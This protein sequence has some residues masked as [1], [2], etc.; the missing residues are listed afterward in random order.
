MS[1][2]GRT[3]SAFVR[4][5]SRGSRADGSGIAERGRLVLVTEAVH[6]LTRRGRPA[7]VNAVAHEI[8]IDQSGASRL[9]RDAAETGCPIPRTSE[10]DGRRRR[11]SVTPTGD[12]MLEQA[13]DRQERVFTRLTEGWSGQRRREFR[14]AMTDLLDRS[15]TLDV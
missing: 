3:L 6:S 13:H 4:H 9:L 14:Q 15:H 11:A 7:T 12:T 2:L 10:A 1:G 8:V 5:R